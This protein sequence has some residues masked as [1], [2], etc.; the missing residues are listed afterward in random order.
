MP[1]QTLIRSKLP[2]VGT[3]IFTVMSQ[4]AQEH[5]AINLSQ[6]FPDFD[7]DPKLLTFVTEAM[8]K[9]FNQYAPMAG[10]PLLRER[11]AEKTAALY[12][13][14]V[15][16]M[17]EITV[18]SG[19]SEAL[20][21]AIMALVEP[22]D[23]VI[24]FEPAYDLYTPAIQ[25]AQGKVVPI[26]LNAT[27]YSIPWAEVA[28]KLTPKTK[29]LILN[30][31]HNPT[32]SIL[33]QTDFEQLTA[34]LVNH[35]AWVLSDEVYEHIIFDGH[36]H[37]SVLRYPALRERSLVVSSFGKTYHTTGWKIGYCIA[38]PALTAEFRK[39]HQFNTFSTPTPLQHALAAFLPFREAYLE[40]SAFYQERRDFFAQL[41]AQTP[42]R[43]L[44]C[45]G[46]YFQLASYGH[47][48]QE[49]D[50]VY[51]RRLTQEIGVAS[52]PVSVFYTDQV[53]NK[54]IRFCFAKKYETM[55]RAVERLVQHQAKL[56]S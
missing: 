11:I 29:L 53:D 26:S 22:G 41:L 39:V 45:Q 46:T 21:N 43:L 35:S 50:T 7:P 42:F 5:Q 13:A 14:E 54:V 31:P 33:Q 25:L 28:Q 9:G 2:Q 8:Q 48:S 44:P 30:T 37:Q 18:V 12:G 51:A 56:A 15:H 20:F 4:L 38:P 16:P 1:T 23:E 36:Q 10:L 3:T 6:G 27:D 55:E 24:I 17:D 47:L 32:G 34:L 49:P 19:A 52:I 40:L